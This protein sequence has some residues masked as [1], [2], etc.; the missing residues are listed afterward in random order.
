MH[1]EHSYQVVVSKT[2]IAKTGSSGTKN[3]AL[4][5]VDLFLPVIRNIQNAWLLVLYRDL[6]NRSRSNIHSNPLAKS[7]PFGGLGFRRK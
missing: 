2:A 7:I 1:H 4:G 3:G 6:P 5:L